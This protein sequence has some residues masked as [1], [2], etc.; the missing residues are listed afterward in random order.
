M[1]VCVC[2]CVCVCDPHAHPR[3]G[4][5][6]LKSHKDVMYLRETLCLDMTEE[7]AAE[8]FMNEVS[9]L[10]MFRLLFSFALLSA[11]LSSLC[12]GFSSHIVCVCVL[13]LSSE[14]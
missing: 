10:C 8:A 9:L 13:F 7:E 3:K 6:E 4:I 1:C 2:V 5:P 11:L 14:F 12:I